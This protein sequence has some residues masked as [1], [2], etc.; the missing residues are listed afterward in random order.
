MSPATATRT[1]GS[2]V[3]TAGLHANTAAFRA[4]ASNRAIAVSLHFGEMRGEG[5]DVSLGWMA[6]DD[7]LRQHVIGGL[8]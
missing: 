4:T 6:D 2:N 8:S 1:R 7:V 3:F 5:G